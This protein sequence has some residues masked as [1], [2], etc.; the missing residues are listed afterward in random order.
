[1]WRIYSNPDPHGVLVLEKK[2]FKIFQ[3]IFYSFDLPLEEGYFLHLN[4]IESLSP[5][6]DL[7]HVWL[8]LAQWFWRRSPKCKMLQMDGFRAIRKAHWRFQLR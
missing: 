4:K 5:K 6:D 8:K 2:I 3:C 1:V 7:C